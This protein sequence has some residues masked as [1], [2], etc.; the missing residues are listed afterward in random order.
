MTHYNPTEHHDKLMKHI[1]TA[2]VCNIGLDEPQIPMQNNGKPCH[3]LRTEDEEYLF[4]DFELWSQL[5]QDALDFVE[6]WYNW[7]TSFCEQMTEEE[8]DKTRKV[9]INPTEGKI[10][11]VE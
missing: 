6:G 3:L 2:I 7:N 9:V 5:V 8:Y 10:S 4:T 11:V 1:A